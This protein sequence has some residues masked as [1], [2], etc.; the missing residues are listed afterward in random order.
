MSEDKTIQTVVDTTQLS[1]LNSYA[2]SGWTIQSVSAFVVPYYKQHG[3]YNPR[4]SATVRYVAL[5]SK[6]EVEK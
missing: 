3:K 4:P 5:L 6:T 1:V 2:E